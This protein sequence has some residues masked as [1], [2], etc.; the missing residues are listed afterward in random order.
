M[1]KTLLSFTAAA[2]LAG[3][4]QAEEINKVTFDLDRTS[5]DQISGV[6]T[7]DSRSE[8]TLKYTGGNNVDSYSAAYTKIST[9]D[10]D[11]TSVDGDRYTISKRKDFNDAFYNFGLSYINTD[12]T[13]L[14]DG[15][16]G[17][18]NLEI[19]KDFSGSKRHFGLGTAYSYYGDGL[20]K[21]NNPSGVGILQL[22]PYAG[23]NTPL[24]NGMLDLKT[25][26][27]VTATMSEELT[28]SSYF[29]YNIINTLTYGKFHATLDVALGETVANV[30]D[31]GYKITNTTD[32]YKDSINFG[33]SVDLDKNLDAGFN[34]T[35]GDV[36]LRGQSQDIS[37]NRANFY[38]AYSF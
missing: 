16:V 27:K 26:V 38:L 29:G 33:V 17:F 32:V 15:F 31:N 6:T 30:N 23:L 2:L 21:G 28:D 3:S 19:D 12:E 1:K 18:F 37:Y 7:L 8:A 4:L 14:G 35:T 34:F 22:A 25:T 10:V 9:S 36:Q 11:G 5:Y 20:D 13:V 24:L